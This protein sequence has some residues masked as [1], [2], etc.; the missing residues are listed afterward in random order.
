[1]PR[2]F[3][4]CYA[5]VLVHGCDPARLEAAVREVEAQRITSCFTAW[6]PRCRCNYLLDT[7]VAAFPTPS[8]H[9]THKLHLLARLRE[10]GAYF[11]QKPA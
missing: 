9:H 4:P 3:D 10:S 6:C 5:S 8:A 11:W 2:E 7:D 1:M